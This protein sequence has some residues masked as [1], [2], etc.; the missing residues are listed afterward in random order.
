MI[1]SEVRQMYWLN[2]SRK[3]IREVHVAEVHVADD[4]KSAGT[5]P[6]AQSRQ[7]DVIFLER[8]FSS[9]ANQ[10]ASATGG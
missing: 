4:W 5:V 6:C 2:R 10:R 7:N 1:T 8:G 3:D 9:L